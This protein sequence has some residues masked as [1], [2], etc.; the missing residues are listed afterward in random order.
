VKLVTLEQASDHLRRDT[1]DDNNDLSL[2]IE[3]ASGAV[4]RYLNGAPYWV[5]LLGP[6]GTPLL[7][8]SGDPIYEQDTAGDRIVLPEVQN[9]T[10]MLVGY[11]YKERDG[12]NEHAVPAQF[13]YGYL[14]IGVTALLFPLRKLASA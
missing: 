1:S 13:G 10:L 7:D 8:S 5:P 4:L 3:A 11:F 14:P 9:A 6:D 2:K 12:S